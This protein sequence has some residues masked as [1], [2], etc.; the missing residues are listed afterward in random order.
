MDARKRTFDQQGKALVELALVVPFLIMFSYFA[1][2]GIKYCRFEQ[3]LSVVS[4][5]AGRAGFDCAF[6]NVPRREM[7]NCLRGAVETAFPNTL[8]GLLDDSDLVVSVWE[9]TSAGAPATL[10]GRY[11]RGQNATTRFTG[12]LVR[13]FNSYNANK[14]RIVVSEAMNEQASLTN[15]FSGAYYSVTIF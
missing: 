6:S 12:G 4:R 13:N 5:E 10:R 14:R 2:E 3:M 15:W 8:G 11:V 1:V 7:D 9:F